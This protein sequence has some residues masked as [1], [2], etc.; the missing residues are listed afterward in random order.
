MATTETWLNRTLDRAV[1]ALAPQWQLKRTKARIATDLVRRHYGYEAASVGRRTQNWN[2]SAGD[3]NSV[4]GFASLARLREV[5][6]DLVRNNPYA[7]A[8]LATIAD[9]TVGWGIVA[10]Q[11][12]DHPNQKVA[13]AWKAWAETTACDADGRHDLYGLQKLIMT[14][15]AQDGEVLVR[16]RNRLPV[17]GLPIPLQLQVLESDL[18]DAYKTQV[19]MDNGHTIIQ[20]VEFDQV[21]RRVAYWMFPVHPG[22]VIQSFGTLFPASRPIPASEI[23]H[24][25]K[26]K[27]P[28]QHRAG[29]WFAPTIVRFKEFDE[30]EDA[31]LMKQKI[32]ACL[33][34]MTTDVD[35]SAPGLG[36]ADDTATPPIDMLEPGAI[37]N[38]P[39]GRSVEVVSP[40]S[41]QD[42]E[43]YCKVTL[44]AIATGLGCS[45]ED[46]TGDYTNLP[47]SAARMSRLRHW[48][49]VT[50]WRWN[51]LIP[52]FCDPVW[53]WAM[54]A[55]F[56]MGVAQDPG[57][58]AQWTPPPMPL[59]DPDKEGLAIM[60]NVR[61][62]IQSL[63]GA[64][65]E[66]GFDPEEQL[67]EMAEDNALLDK[68]GLK[69]DSDA[70][71]MTQ[72]G[73]LQGT[74]VGTPQ[75]AVGDRV[76]ATADHMPGM[77]GQAGSVNEA[78]AGD[79][80]YYAVDFDT[81]MGD[82]N[83]H[84]WLTETELT[85]EGKA[86]PGKKKMT[87]ARGTTPAPAD[88]GGGGQ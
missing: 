34:V 61:S 50:D 80:P 11:A 40:P 18:L 38:V 31:T 17:D 19:L 35:G 26:A 66:R 32:A 60:R 1:G 72:A 39:P 16:R 53:A 52:Q 28:G 15:V 27:R 13:A 75:F 41:V 9:H 63:S 83:P 64:L 59:L 20:G 56:L 85:A 22:A 49:R 79:P 29:S 10:K 23:L 8:A 68:L 3:A 82:G 7:E 43:P 65:R 4:N 25:F 48:D 57:A 62:G 30:F 67:N 71:Y 87:M 58:V 21:G 12:G 55:L 88:T 44:R 42:Y 36:T 86:T 24:I 78:H 77:V 46:I 5:A 84:K 76:I 2:R 73:Q 70:R 51:L 45:Y 74:A 69:L 37:L 14:A 6:R 33:A 54:Q 47:F 81:P